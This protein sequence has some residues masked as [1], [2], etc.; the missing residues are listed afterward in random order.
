MPTNADSESRAAPRKR[1]LKGG[2]VA[3]SAR[4]A[5]LPCV[6]RDLSDSGVRLQVEQASSVPDTFELLID[7]DGFEARCSVV[8]RRAREI[9]ACFVTPPTRV[10]PKR[11]QVVGSASSAPANRPLLR[12]MPSPQ[13]VRP[14]PAPAPA[15]KSETPSR[16]TPAAAPPPRP[17][18]AQP[19]QRIPILIADDDPDDRMLIRDAFVE[20]AFQHP[21]AFVENGEELLAYLR[22]EAPYED[23][24]LPGLI[25]LDLNMPRMDGRT[26]LMHLKTDSRLRRIPVVVLTTSNAE[27][28]IARTYDLGVS[29]FIPKPNTF[30]GL[31]EL[32]QSLN[33]YWMRF[34]SI[35]A[36]T[37]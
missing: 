16:T 33:V 25:L 15:P 24:E 8:W 34:A 11:T 19:A 35:P 28:D 31:K 29:A 3:F 6:V 37:G 2:I 20:S 17:A 27:E 26:A 21:I 18:P 9:G 22:G 32:V 5:T 23:R 36:L 30:D 14:T 13:Q 1:M 4:H 12:R 10:A 7:L